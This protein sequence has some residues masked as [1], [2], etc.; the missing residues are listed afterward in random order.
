MS[1]PV[2]LI[3]GAWQGSWV[4]KK[5]IPLLEAAGVEVHAVDL[6][7]NGVDDTPFEDVSLDLYVDHVGALI[8][9]I[10]R[11]VSLVGHSGG[12]V[13]ATEVGE[14]YVEQVARV[15][16]VAGMMLPPGAGFSDLLYW[17][18]AVKRGLL[19]I[20]PH[21]EWSA[22][23]SQSRVPPEAGARIFLNDVPYDTA[24]IGARNLTPQ[25]EGG[26]SIVAEWTPERF[27]TLPRLY[28]E[29]ERDLSV[30]PAFQRR[31][32]EL[33]PGAERVELDTG[34]APQISAPEK[35]AGALLPFL[36]GE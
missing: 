18:H 11:P 23:G 29:C 30:V 1:D 9:K 16:Y 4:W 14:R 2:I 26:R 27:G 34:H 8:E 13:V 36:T 20:G 21:L 15:A 35:L 17:E 10:G 19:G 6:P 25:A 7:G 33:V 24:L 32:Q 31:M 22:D 5:L 3:H 28:V 12:G